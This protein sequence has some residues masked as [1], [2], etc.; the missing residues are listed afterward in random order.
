MRT[1]VVGDIH[2]CR[3]ELERLL[4]VSGFHHGVDRL[5][6]CGDLLDRGPDSLGV[7]R[8]ARR[9][10]AECV[11]GNHEEKHLRYHR[12]ALRARLDPSYVI[13]MRM[14]HPEVHRLLTDDDFAFIE[15]MPLTLD[16]GSNTVVVHGGFS[17]D[18]PR[19]RPRMASCRVRYVQPDTR[20]FVP[21]SDGFTQSL[22]TVFWTTKYLGTKNVIYGHHSYRAPEKRVRPC[23]IWTL[24]IDTGCCFGGSLTGYWVESQKLVSVPATRKY[25]SDISEPKGL[26]RPQPQPLPWGTKPPP[27]PLSPVQTRMVP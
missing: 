6:L 21:S 7:L 9:L 13:P 16:V 15:A 27:P 8:L 11:L 26:Q 24:G 20:K 22:G 3:Q 1:L 14:P 2:G 5:V 18:S 23:G 10:G 17:S 19:W 25:Y 12:H 4:K